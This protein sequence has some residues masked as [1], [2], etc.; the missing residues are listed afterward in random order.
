MSW[1]A[2]H[3]F[4]QGPAHIRQQGVHRHLSVGGVQRPWCWSSRRLPRP[5]ASRLLFPFPVQKDFDRFHSVQLP[6]P[7]VEERAWEV[8]AMPQPPPPRFPVPKSASAA[9]AALIHEA[10]KPMRMAP[11]AVAP[12]SKGG[13]GKG[14]A[15]APPVP[16]ML[17]NRAA[18]PG[19]QPYA[20]A[21]FPLAAAVPAAA[22]AGKKGAKGK[23]PVMIPPVLE[24]PQ[25]PK[26]NGKN[27]KRDGGPPNPL[28][29]MMMQRAQAL[30]EM[31]MDH[32]R[33]VEQ[34]VMARLERADAKLRHSIEMAAGRQ[35]KIYS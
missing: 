2:G 35:Y 3:S 4:R 14:M 8:P 20:A 31:Q 12:T 16:P 21:A 33:R 24:Q 30:Q 15:T 22:A 26:G 11:T 9:P 7:K 13:R 27:G 19:M 29:G 10:M 23:P 28:A 25:L 18:V 5:T 17:S 32:Y 34:L 6:K 1:L